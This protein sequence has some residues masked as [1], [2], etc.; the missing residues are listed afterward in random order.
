MKILRILWE[1]GPSKVRSINDQL[2]KENNI[3]YTSTL[4][5][6]QTMAEKGMLTREKEGISHIY[7]SAI[8]QQE[9]QKS[10][11]NKILEYDFSGSKM[12][13][14]MQ[15]FG[16]E[17]TT[18]KDMDDIRLFIEKMDQEKTNEST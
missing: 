8:D 7:S 5:L 16:N 3:G 13:L 12:N 9:S 15:L 6:M 4:K 11:L 18:K 1:Q 2:N 14:I 10:I 17:K